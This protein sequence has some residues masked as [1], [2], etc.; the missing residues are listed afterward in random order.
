MIRSEY[1][2]VRGNYVPAKSFPRAIG[3][4]LAGEILALGTSTQTTP[5][6]RV[7]GSARLITK[8]AR[9]SDIA[10]RSRTSG[11][12]FVVIIADWFCKLATARM[13][14]LLLS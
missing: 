9:S 6:T 12:Q 2:Y 14:T 8:T 5:A 13:N 10:K 7:K 1:N 3:Q 11:C 4:Q